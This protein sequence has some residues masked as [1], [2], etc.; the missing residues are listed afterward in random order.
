[1]PTIALVGDLFL[2]QPLPEPSALAG[3]GPVLRSADIAFGNL[4]APVS[5]VGAPTEKWIN[6]RMSPDLL[7]DVKRLGFNLLTLA[8]NHLFDYGEAAF[9]DTLRHLD[10]SELRYVGAGADLDAAWRAQIIELAGTRVAFLGAAST[11]GPGSAATAD[12]PGVAP[13]HIAESYH[14]DPA[15]SLEQP[16]SAPYVHTRAWKD[17]LQRACQAVADARANA[18]FVIVA[19]HWGVPPAWRPRFQDGLADYQVEVGH[20]LVEAGADLIVGAHPHSLQEVEVYRGKPIFYSLGNFVF[21]HN[22]GPMRE[23]PVS[24]HSPYT[25]NIKRRNRNW[26]ETI[27]LLAE[28]AEGA[29]HCKLLPA[30]LDDEGNP[31]L[32]QG[33]EA[34]AVIERLAVLS[35]KAALHYHDGMGYLVQ[36]GVR[37]ENQSRS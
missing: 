28:V 23:T 18:E 37:S 31:Q 7:D 24:R 10:D 16:G 1:M 15:A 25:L 19:M 27:I 8:N 30:L 36:G 11:L 2:Q 22:R 12:R 32:L 33:D 34:R 3:V 6:M 14:I 4:E 35:P 20:A 9:F 13:V 17:D 26:S 29:V 5:T 21:H